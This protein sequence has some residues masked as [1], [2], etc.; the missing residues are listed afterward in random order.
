MFETT[1]R[2]AGQFDLL[3]ICPTKEQVEV[4]IN[5]LSYGRFRRPVMMI[6]IDGAHAPTRPEPSDWKGKHGK[7]KWKEVKGFGV[8]LIDSDR[9]EHLISWHQIQ[10]D[11]ELAYKSFIY[12][13]KKSF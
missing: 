1:H 3:E 11:K 13:S 4:K 6:A 5:E 2:I 7:G 8:Y 9:I 12:R 10:D